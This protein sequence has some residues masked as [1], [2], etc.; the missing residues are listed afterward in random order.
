MIETML[1]ARDLCA[2]LWALVKFG[3][4]RHYDNSG[5]VV[6]YFGHNSEPVQFS[7]G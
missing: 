5:T 6:K 3:T 4:A 7:R 2:L 1:S